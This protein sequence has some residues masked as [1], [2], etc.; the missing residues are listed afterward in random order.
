MVCDARLMT[1]DRFSQTNVFELLSR[2]MK[3]RRIW[4]FY[5]TKASQTKAEGKI[6]MYNVMT[7]NKH[8]LRPFIPVRP[9]YVLYCHVKSA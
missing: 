9:F 1:L 4:F 6:K 8:L 7:P 3:R 5:D 2:N